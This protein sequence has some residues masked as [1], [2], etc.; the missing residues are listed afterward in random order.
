MSAADP[1]GNE[2]ARDFPNPLDTNV[3][4]NE[5]VG[6]ALVPVANGKF[7]REALPDPKSLNDW[8]LTHVCEQGLRA[9]RLTRECKPYLL[10]ARA[11]YKKPGRRVPVPGQPTWTEWVER[12]SGYSVR[13]IQLLL[14]ESGKSGRKRGGRKPDENFS[15]GSGENEGGV[16][17]AA[18][19]TPG[20]PENTTANT[21]PIVQLGAVS[22]VELEEQKSLREIAPI[23]VTLVFS[24][25]DQKLF[26]T[27]V[28][29]LFAPFRL[30]IPETDN[31]QII[32][33]RI[34]LEAL[35]RE[36]E[37]RAQVAA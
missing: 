16:D 6:E 17:V 34:V 7:G 22:L 8:Q 9:L 18:A 13:T 23:R 4:D 33:S 20:K 32:K 26:D 10:E 24:R 35:R 2:P 21:E 36:F 12:V 19:A 27:Y 28:T 14:Q 5:S 29:A 30:A 15:R 37:A 31:A 3:T 25:A 1:Q 11:R